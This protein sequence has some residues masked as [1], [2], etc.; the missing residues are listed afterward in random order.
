MKQGKRP[1]RKQKELIGKEKIGNQFLNPNKWLV[2]Q[3]SASK[4]LLIHKETG[5]T[6]DLVL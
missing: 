1:T 3:F 2:R 5:K 6:R 4:M